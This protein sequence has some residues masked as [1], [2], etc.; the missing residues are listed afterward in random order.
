MYGDIVYKLKTDFS[1]KSRKIIIRFKCNGS[2]LDVMRQSACLVLNSVMIHIYASLF[3]CTLLG[4]VDVRLYDG[5][6]V[7]L[8]ILVVWGGRFSTVSWP[9]EV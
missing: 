4:H 2:N 7:K 6:D 8:Y 1:D 5:P 3:N 9:T